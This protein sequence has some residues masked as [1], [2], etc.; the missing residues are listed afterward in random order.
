[1]ADKIVSLGARD[2]EEV[3]AELEQQLSA[4]GVP[5]ARRLRAAAL[6]EEVFSAVRDA[7]DGAGLLRCAF[8]RPGTVTLQYRDRSGPL[9]PDL[10]LVRRLSRHLCTDGMSAAF[11]EGRCVI[12]VR[13]TDRA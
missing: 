11:Y 9:K 10:R 2:L 4:Q 7:K 5:T 13:A 6:V 3:L 8:P 12:T 1:M